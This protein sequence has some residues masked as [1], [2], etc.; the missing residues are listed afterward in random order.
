MLSCASTSQ[1]ERAL[2]GYLI[3]I[4]TYVDSRT[5]T[6]SAGVDARVPTLQPIISA[7]PRSQ[8]LSAGE[9]PALVSPMDIPP[10][11][12]SPEGCAFGR[13]GTGKR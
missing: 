8:G 13:P 4:T 10:P 12:V 5:E 3:E 9:H 7:S 6:C 11:V 1:Q 2:F